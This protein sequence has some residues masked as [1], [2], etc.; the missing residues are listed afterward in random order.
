MTDSKPQY[1]M[2]REHLLAWRD[3]SVRAF[4]RA[5]GGESVPQPHRLLQ[6]FLGDI[7]VSAHTCE[8]RSVPVGD[9]DD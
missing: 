8:P 7:A 2:S 3:V 9:D 4:D 1:L 6:D 5:I